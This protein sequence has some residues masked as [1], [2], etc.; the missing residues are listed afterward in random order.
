MPLPTLCDS[1]AKCRQLFP[2]VTLTV[3]LLEIDQNIVTVQAEKTSTND[4][5]QDTSKEMFNYNTEIY[6]QSVIILSSVL[7]IFVFFGLLFEA[8]THK[9]VRRQLSTKISMYCLSIPNFS[10]SNTTGDGK[11]HVH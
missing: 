11:F 10:L 7:G 8:L 2:A 5:K 9:V 6:K 3:L 1:I 4:D